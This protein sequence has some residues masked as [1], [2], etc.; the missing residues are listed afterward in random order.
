MKRVVTVSCPECQ[1]RYDFSIQLE[2]LRSMGVQAKCTRCGRSFDIVQRLREL[3]SRPSTRPPAQAQS[4]GRIRPR[5]AVREIRK[6]AA[7]EERLPEI[8]FLSEED[9]LEVQEEAVPRPPPPPA[10]TR[11]EPT[12]ANDTDANTRPTR[13][14]PS[15]LTP[16]SREPLD[17]GPVSEERPCFETEGDTDSVQELQQEVGDV[18]LRD[19][20]E[21]DARDEPLEATTQ[22]VRSAPVELEELRDR[23]VGSDARASLGEPRVPHFD[24]VDGD[25][26]REV[27]AVRRDSPR[28]SDEPE[29]S[30]V[31]TAPPQARATAERSWLDRVP[32]G[33]ETLT[34]PQAAGEEALIWLLTNTC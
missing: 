8:Q 31:A 12:A 22:S 32:S 7:R 15:G 26:D 2:R 21:P 27:V 9:L 11:S 3:L 16:S 13:D 33:F 19:E 1:T 6:P 24:L 4:I 5:P 14:L 20:V 34:R 10:R 17:P 28:L 25:D 30:P 23:S 29:R 18:E